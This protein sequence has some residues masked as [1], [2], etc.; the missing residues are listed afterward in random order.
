MS[1]HARRMGTDPEQPVKHMATDA[2]AI[3]A[4]RLAGWRSADRVNAVTIS[5]QRWAYLGPEGTF[6]EE[7]AIELRGRIAPD[8]EVDLVPAVSVA[9]ALAELRSG[10]VDAACVPLENSVEG[11]VPLT[12][13]ELTHGPALVIAAEAYVTIAFDLLV[14]LGT[15]LADVSSV[16]S[17]PHG[18]AQIRD[19]LA[20]NLPTAERVVSSS[21]GAAA[22]A[23]AAGELDAA[24]AGSRAGKHYGLTSLAVDIGDVHAAMTRFVL[25]RRPGTLPAR[26][27]NDRTSLVIFVDNRPGTLLAVLSEM[28]DRGINLTRLESRPTRE[29]VGEYFFLLDADG[30]IAEPAMAE[31]VG[32]VHRRAAGLRFLGSYPRAIGQTGPAPAYAT[33]DAYA[34]AAEFVSGIQRQ[35]S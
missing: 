22:A 13:D 17:H 6:T 20:A 14:R 25:I 26:T 23:V 18:H 32:G 27:G 21:N 5:R 4:A 34:A 16:G 24:A 35:G 8:A 1:V 19:W 30:H 33:A 2:D 15:T 9:A 10:Q 29:H 31:A 11:S 12:L 3:R 28:A 7:A